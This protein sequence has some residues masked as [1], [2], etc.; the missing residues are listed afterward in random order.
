MAYKL[1]FLDTETTGN[2]KKDYLCQ[3][4]YS[5]DGSRKM[6]LFKPPTQIPPGASAVHH[7]TNKMVADKPAFQF[8]FEYDELK[9]LLHDE[10]VILV[11]HN[12]LFDIGMLEKEGLK[13]PRFI[14]TLRIA[15]HLDPDEK[16]ES[17]RLQFLRYL[18]EIDIE[19]AAHDA[20]GDVLVL[21]KLFERLLKK[22]SEHTN[23]NT[24]LA[25]LE[26]MDISSR[27][28]LIKTFKFGKH[29]GKKVEDVAKIDRG[30]LEWFL[31]QKLE[32]EDD[33]EDWIY[34]LKYYLGK[35]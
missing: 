17:Y 30:Y 8:S 19:A 20:L 24:E 9:K 27:P 18:L 15:R 33:D 32:K 6:A 26:M 1:L 14:C 31:A 3:I 16:I 25:V 22:M 13:V 23:K 21:E 35:L 34:T 10:E 12:A 5:I 2:E 28:V 11:A 7:I 4:A 29:S